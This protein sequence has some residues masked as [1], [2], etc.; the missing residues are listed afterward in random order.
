MNPD[1]YLRQL[2]DIQGLDTI[3]HWPLAP[4]W[5]LLLI[6]LVLGLMLAL[7]LWPRL[8]GGQARAPWRADAARQ[9]RQLRQLNQRQGGQGSAETQRQLAADL[10]ELLRRIAMARCG[11]DSC[12]GLQGQAWLAWLKQHDPK[13]FD[14]PGQGRALIELPFAPPRLIETNGSGGPGGQADLGRLIR[15]AQAWISA[16]EHCPLQSGH[17]GGQ[18]P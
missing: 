5:W 4:G 7:R 10:S 15:A 11:R 18:R 13:G 6:L 9:L 16:A 17:E 2:R 14:W 1:I 3:G 12:A 8:V